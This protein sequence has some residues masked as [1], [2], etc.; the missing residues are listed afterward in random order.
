[1]K[2]KTIKQSWDASAA[3]VLNPRAVDKMI[4]GR[5][6]GEMYAAQADL[7][8]TA[9]A[10]RKLLVK[11]DAAMR[12]APEPVKTVH[13]ELDRHRPGSIFGPDPKMLRKRAEELVDRQYKR[14]SAE[15]LEEKVRRAEEAHNVFD[16]VYFGNKAIGDIWYHELEAYRIE[17][18][19]QAAL[20]AAIQG[21]GVPDKPTRVRDFVKAA[22]LRKMVRTANAIARCPLSEHRK[23]MSSVLKR[24]NKRDTLADMPWPIDVT[25]AGN[26]RIVNATPATSRNLRGALKRVIEDRL[27]T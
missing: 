27:A 13:A 8:A 2:S 20:C 26:L 14:T 19:R 24:L 18:A 16:T 23:W 9:A 21:Y 15:I 4:A 7:R 12:P 11:L 17:G 3:L 5:H 10:V 6:R 22:D 1:M 25:Y